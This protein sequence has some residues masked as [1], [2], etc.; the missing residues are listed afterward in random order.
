[1]S[2]QEVR[3]WVRL[4][5]LRAQGFH[6]RRQAPF[7]RYIL[8]FV[9][10][11]RRLV[12]EVDGPHHQEGEQPLRDDFRDEVLRYE[13]F[14]TLRFSTRKVH[15][16]I[17]VVM[18]VICRALDAVSPTRPLRGHPPYEGEGRQPRFLAREEVRD[19]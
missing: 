19:D 4:R 8:D 11:N 15:E 13:G 14:Q 9:C 17:D 18:D 12:V 6:F 3:L 1:M 16:E 2:G 7:R 5:Q 10:F